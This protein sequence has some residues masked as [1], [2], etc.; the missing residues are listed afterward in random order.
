MSTLLEK[1]FASIGARVKVRPAHD[2]EASSS[3]RVDVLR[4]ED[5][6]YFDL[7]AGDLPVEVIATDPARRHLVLLVRNKDV[8]EKYLM[9]HDERHWF[10]AAV[11]GA[12]VKD[13]RSAMAALWPKEV[14]REDGIRQGEWIFRPIEGNPPGFD[15]RL[16]Y[17]NEPLRRGRSKPHVA[18]ELTRTGG[19]SVCV[20][21]RFPNGVT[22]SAMQ[23]IIK[24]DPK[25]RTWGWQRMVRDAAVFVRGAVRHSDHATVKLDG[26]HRVYLNNERFAAWAEKVVFLD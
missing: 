1:R 25:A 12:G 16:I 3:F 26:W 9:G 15:S 4:D 2:R 5:G 23:A 10:V 8:K 24:K 20:C 13:V 22:E 18:Q 6:E 14:P 7:R 21:S 11:P 17:H 19:V